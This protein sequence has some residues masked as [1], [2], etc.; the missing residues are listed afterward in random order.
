LRH[1]SG[2]RSEAG[3]VMQSEGQSRSSLLLNGSSWLTPSTQL[4]ASYGRDVSMDNGFKAQDMFQLRL[5][6]IF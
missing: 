6:T 1:Y 3:G 4:M 5:L 2:G